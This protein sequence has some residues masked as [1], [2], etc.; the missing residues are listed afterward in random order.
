MPLGWQGGSRVNDLFR[1]SME[2]PS[3][4][5][6]ISYESFSEQCASSMARG[7]PEFLVLVRLSVS[8]AHS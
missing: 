2:S 4:V 1:K 7:L 5:V 8:L 3:F 6:M